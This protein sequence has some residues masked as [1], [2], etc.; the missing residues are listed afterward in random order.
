MQALKKVDSNFPFASANGNGRLFREMFSDA[1]IAKRYK[2][3]KTKINYYI[4]FGL[5]PYFM[6]FLQDDFLGR[7][8]SFTFDETT[9]SL[10][11]NK[12]QYDGF[13]QYWSNSMKC[14][15]IVLWIMFY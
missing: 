2:Q 9:A 7:A 10:M 14:I 3:S 6:Q 15:D 12:K 13:I 5:A 8:L 11:K 1:D 4:Q